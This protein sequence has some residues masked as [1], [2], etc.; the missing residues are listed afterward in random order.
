MVDVP[1]IA[2]VEYVLDRLLRIPAY[3]AIGVCLTARPP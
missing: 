2:G 1:M 3:F